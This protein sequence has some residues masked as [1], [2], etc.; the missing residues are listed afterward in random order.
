[1][2]RLEFHLELVENEELIIV[3]SGYYREKLGIPR[4]NEKIQ[5]E[6]SEVNCCVIKYLIA[7]F[8]HPNPFVRMSIILG[9]LSLGI[10]IISLVIALIGRL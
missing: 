4:T 9:F 7:P 2:V 6:I 8:H 3:I 5:L 1:M 10:G